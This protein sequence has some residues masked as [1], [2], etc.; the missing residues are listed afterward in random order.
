MSLLPINVSST[1]GVL[2]AG[3]LVQCFLL[4]VLI[5]QTYR[6]YTRFSYDTSIL[7]VLVCTIFLLLCEIG[8]SICCC[9]ALYTYVVIQYGNPMAFLS[10]PISGIMACG[11][12]GIIEC[13]VQLFFANRIR[14]FG[15]F[16]VYFLI[17]YALV[18]SMRFGLTV[19]ALVNQIRSATLVIFIMNWRWLVILVLCI[20]CAIDH[21][22]SAFLL[23]Y[24][25]FKKR[26]RNVE[27]KYKF[28]SF[29]AKRS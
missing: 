21:T 15:R 13:I 8:H 28:H 12:N 5:V 23:Y 3:N 17:I 22:I 11:I 20:R 18:A 1:L 29:T 2:L 6:Y 26:N 10:L 4:G 16:S 24:L 19:A 7:K 14:I 27:A 9:H 25:T